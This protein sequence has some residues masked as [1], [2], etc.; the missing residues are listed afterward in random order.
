MVAL[1][2]WASP[3]AL[4]LLLLQLGSRFADAQKPPSSAGPDPVKYFCS[5]WWSQCGWPFPIFPYSSHLLTRE[6]VIKN[7]VLYIDSG[8]EKFNVSKDLYFGIS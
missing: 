4:V 6:A 7:D 8:I 2:E 3:C 5:R 1:R